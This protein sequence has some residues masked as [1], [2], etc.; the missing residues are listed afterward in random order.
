MYSLRILHLDHNRYGYIID[1]VVRPIVI[2][3]VAGFAGVSK[4]L[5]TLLSLSM[6]N[7]LS[8][9]GALPD[10][11]GTTL[12]NGRMKQLFIDSNR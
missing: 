8:L 7:L 2:G 10:N 6:D 4:L 3:R 5:L 1:R 11:F 12:G 9:S